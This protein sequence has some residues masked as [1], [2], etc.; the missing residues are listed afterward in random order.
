MCG[1]WSLTCQ[2][3]RRRRGCCSPS[4]PC[5]R[6]RVREGDHRWSTS[7]G[8]AVLHSS[9]VVLRRQ[10]DGCRWVASLAALVAGAGSVDAKILAYPDPGD[11]TAGCFRV[12]GGPVCLVCSRVAI[13]GVVVSEVVRTRRCHCRR[14]RR[15]RGWCSGT[16][17][18]PEGH[19]CS[20]G[21]APQLAFGRGVVVWE[22]AAPWRELP[23]HRG[24]RSGRHGNVGG[25]VLRYRCLRG[26]HDLQGR[27][28]KGPGLGHSIARW[29]GLCIRLRPSGALRSH[30][31]DVARDRPRAQPAFTMR[32]D[33]PRRLR[34]PV[35][36]SA[37]DP[38][39]WFARTGRVAA[40]S[41]T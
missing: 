3:R 20:L 37:P 23:S 14:G 10:K 32:R 25:R 5:I 39:V 29:P 22:S 35:L 26:V 19:G 2:Y 1:W 17:N 6:E 9:P 13:D 7:S 16:W 31:V 30:Y 41:A 8:P 21:M 24:G 18:V 36:R 11:A 12:R 40:H 28:I 33:G 34:H 4:V 38:A 15:A 27:H